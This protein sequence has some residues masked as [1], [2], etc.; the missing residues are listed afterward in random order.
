[1][2]STKTHFPNVPYYFYLQVNSLVGNDLSKNIFHTRLEH[3]PRTIYYGS[4][5]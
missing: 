5:K 2:T 3:T 1:M 4:G